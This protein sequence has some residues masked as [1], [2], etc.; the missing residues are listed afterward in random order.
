V[1]YVLTVTLNPALDLSSATPRVVPG[2]KLRC[3][4]PQVDPGGGGVNVARAIVKLGG[5]AR[6]FVA[7]G[8]VTG[9][10]VDSLLRAEGLDLLPF[11][12][13]G[14]TRQ[15]LSVTDQ[16]TGEQYRFVLPGPDWDAA[17]CTAVLDALAEAVPVGALGVIS[18]RQPPGLPDDFPLLLVA[19]LAAQGARVIADTSGPAMTVLAAGGGGAPVFLLRQDG[20][21]A[22]LLSGRRITTIPELADL[23]AS[24]VAR[25]AAQNVMLSLGGEGSVLAG[26]DLPARYHCRPPP[27]RVVSAVGAGDSFLGGV[28]LALARD[29]PLPQALCHGTAAA[30]AAVLTSGTELCTKADF[31]RILP[32]CTLG[33]I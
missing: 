7:L 14:E 11:A 21:E 15:S 6:A 23:A 8:G 18:G 29:V 27:T 12:A 17:E 32:Q 24:L 20:E 3:A 16:A 22:A 33:E 26:A 4:T 13:L 9:G 28:S 31:D 1:T 5:D 10:R 30:C 19:R 2:H 25:G